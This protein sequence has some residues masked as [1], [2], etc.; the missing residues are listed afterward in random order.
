[1]ADVGQ[2]TIDIRNRKHPLISFPLLGANGQHQTA[3]GDPFRVKES[4]YIYSYIDYKSASLDSDPLHEF[5]FPPWAVGVL[6]YHR[7]TP[8]ISSSIRFRICDDVRPPSVDAGQDLMLPPTYPGEKLPW[9]IPLGLITSAKRYRPFL[10]TLLNDRLVD[11][12]LIEHLRSFNIKHLI[13]DKLPL[14]TIDQPFVVDLSKARSLNFMTMK[15]CHFGF[16]LQAWR[17]R[18]PHRQPFTGESLYSFSS[19][20]TI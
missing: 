5:K 14:Y 10:Q 13:R 7:S 6:Y 19:P 15:G 20:C 18:S 2:R 17:D 9:E 4:S 16:I 12:A 8:E 1:M 11:H 3:F